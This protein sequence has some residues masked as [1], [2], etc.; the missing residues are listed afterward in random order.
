MNNL[1][2][3]KQLRDDL[4][5][6]L[7]HSTSSEK[8]HDRIRELRKSPELTPESKVLLNEIIDLLH[9]IQS[10]QY[11]SQQMYKKKIVDV[12]HTLLDIIAQQ[13]ANTSNNIN[14]NILSEILKSPKLMLSIAFVL[15]L[16]VTG[17]SLIDTYN[18]RL[19]DKTVEVTN[20]GVK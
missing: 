19:L 6:A 5:E 8:Y 7:N 20:Q 14:N 15:L 4:T 11:T 16:I 18:P 17:I 3:L 1:D 2:I 10:D 12:I 9:L 13:K